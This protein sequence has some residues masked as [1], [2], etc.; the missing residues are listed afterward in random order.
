MNYEQAL[1]NPQTRFTTNPGEESDDAAEPAP[2]FPATMP[3]GTAPLATEEILIPRSP[4]GWDV[5]ERFGPKHPNWDE[6]IPVVGMIWARETS[7]HAVRGGLA[8]GPFF[9]RRRNFGRRSAPAGSVFI[10]VGMFSS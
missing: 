2:S 3:L 4:G 9:R 6:N 10:P 1:V 7:R 5:I 8:P